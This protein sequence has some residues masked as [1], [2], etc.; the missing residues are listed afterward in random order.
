MS[1][2]R[3]AAG[4]VK[5]G[6]KIG[7]QFAAQER[8]E[9]AAPLTVAAT[10]DAPPLG[11]EVT[12][13]ELDSAVN[14]SSRASGIHEMWDEFGHSPETARLSAALLRDTFAWRFPEADHVLVHEAD[15]ASFEVAEVR[16]ADGTPISHNLQI[17]ALEESQYDYG[18][19]SFMDCNFDNEADDQIWSIASDL[20]RTGDPGFREVTKELD[21]CA[22]DVWRLDLR[23]G[24]GTHTAPVA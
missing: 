6:D 24:G 14:F 5:A 18:S 11:D 9:V 1:T 12:V 23:P 2:Q 19:S 10:S 17:G 4:A 3:Q 20:P 7:G 13:A 15:G 22:L 21:D 8:A 16:E